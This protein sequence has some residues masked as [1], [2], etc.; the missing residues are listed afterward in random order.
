M[1]DFRCEDMRREYDAKL[2][3]F[4]IDNPQLKPVKPEKTKK[5]SASAAAAAAAGNA[6]A[7]AA[8]AAANAAT[9]YPASVGMVTNQ[10]GMIMQPAQV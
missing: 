5:T 7:V 8:A 10:S 2:A 9:A 6:A 1:T 3:Q 4:Y